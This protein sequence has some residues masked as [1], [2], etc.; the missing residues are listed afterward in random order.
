MHSKQPDRKRIT[1]ENYQYALDNDPNTNPTFYSNV[2][3]DNQR[4]FQN[5]KDE[6][7]Q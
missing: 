3:Y 5:I 6:E 7:Y 1:L 2:D 4:Y